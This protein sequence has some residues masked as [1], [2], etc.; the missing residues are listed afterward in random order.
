MVKSFVGSYRKVL[1]KKTTLYGLFLEN[2]SGCYVENKLQK[3]KGRKG[4]YSRKEV[5]TK[6][7]ETEEVRS[8]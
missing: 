5:L 2:S 1:S 7:I 4:I 6:M 8:G 3:G